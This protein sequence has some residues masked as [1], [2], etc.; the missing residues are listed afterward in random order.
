MVAYRTV[1]S[2]FASALGLAPDLDE[3][4]VKGVE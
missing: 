4:I 1:R 3:L 2:I